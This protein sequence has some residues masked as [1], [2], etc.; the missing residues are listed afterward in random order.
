MF[1]YL[2]ID[3]IFAPAKTKEKWPGS[4]AGRAHHF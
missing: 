1:V 2:D 4:S 3:T